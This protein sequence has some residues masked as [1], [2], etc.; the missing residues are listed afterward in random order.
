MNKIDRLNNLPDPILHHILSFL[1]T[2]EAVRT[3]VLAKRW[4][5]LW[6]SLP[7]LVLDSKGNESKFEHFVNRLFCLREY[8]HID[9]FK[10]S[11]NAGPKILKPWLLHVLALRPRSLSV[12]SSILPVALPV[13]VFRCESLEE[14]MLDVPYPGI[15][16][17]PALRPKSISL[18]RLRRL[19]INAW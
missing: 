10:I 5:N 14:L 9:S 12:V 1:S 17:I 15:E 2:R 3:C 16:P 19:V 13:S 6:A 7:S 18:S 8:S 4:V 11:C